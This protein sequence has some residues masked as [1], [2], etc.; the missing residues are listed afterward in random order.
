MRSSAGSGAGC[1]W[2]LPDWAIQRLHG[3][4]S[5]PKFFSAAYGRGGG[6]GGEREGK[7]EKEGEEKRGKKGEEKKREGGKE[8]GEGG[9]E[10]REEALDRPD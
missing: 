8:R 9:R 1:R 6:R 5:T 4:S 2:P 3:L 7:K 10:G